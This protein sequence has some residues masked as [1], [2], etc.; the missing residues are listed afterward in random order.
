M[1]KVDWHNGTTTTIT[2]GDALSLIEAIA[3][4]WNREDWKEVI[5]ACKAVANG[6]DVPEFEAKWNLEFVRC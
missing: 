6:E 5:T 2:E 3:D 4:E 1:I